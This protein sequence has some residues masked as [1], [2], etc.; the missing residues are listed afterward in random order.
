MELQFLASSTEENYKFEMKIVMCSET[1]YKGR[2]QNKFF[3][4]KNKQCMT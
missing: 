4:F 3:T 2:L 1:Y